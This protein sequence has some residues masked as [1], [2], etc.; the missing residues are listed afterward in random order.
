MTE[1]HPNQVIP[2][3]EAW[4]A[5]HGHEKPLVLLDT[6]GKVM[7]PALP[8]E[9]AYQRD[10]RIGSRLK[11]LSDNHPGSTV[12]V[13]HHIRKAA[14]GEDWMD[15]TSGTNGLNGAADFTINLHRPRNSEAGVI[16]V[17]GRDVAESE[18]A[19]TSVDN[20]WTLDGSTLAEAAQAA[21]AAR[22]SE[23][24]GDRAAEIVALVA[25]SPQA[26]SPK[27]VA[28]ALGI[29]ATSAGTYL[30]R[31]ASRS[32]HQ[33]GTRP[34]IPLLKV[35]KVLKR[36]G[37]STLSTLSHPTE[38]VCLDC[39]EPLSSYLISAGE[40]RHAGCVDAS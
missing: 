38:R 12:L 16:R 18:Y 9:G 5:V 4:L 20:R 13:I 1:A 22:A 25:R 28:L 37:V 6:L 14:T 36:E 10:Y 21:V 7:P 8:G 2:L 35:W 34:D 33:A 19:V 29:E 40:S 26:V 32:H 3:I 15:S 23:G 27:E 11:R 24:L 31:L 39:G 30:G 17:T